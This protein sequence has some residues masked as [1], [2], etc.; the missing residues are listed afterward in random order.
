[1]KVVQ[2]LAGFYKHF[3]PLDVATGAS[4]AIK[5]LMGSMTYRQ[6]LRYYC[7]SKRERDFLLKLFEL[8]KF[9]PSHPLE[10]KERSNLIAKISEALSLYTRAI[11][12]APPSDAKLKKIRRI[13]IALR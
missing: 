1:M 7:E 12:K 13:P 9:S 10:R 2:K 6:A 11:S 8:M 5:V 4:G 3:E